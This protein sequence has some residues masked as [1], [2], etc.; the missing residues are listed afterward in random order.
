MHHIRDHSPEVLD[1]TVF[2]CR[3]LHGRKARG[4]VPHLLA[5]ITDAFQVRD[6]LD[7]RNDHAQIA[8]G[9][10]ARGENAAAL[11]VNGDLHIVD[12]VVV[13]RHCLTQGTVTLDERR[14]GF[15][16]L[17]LNEAA[18]RQN[19]AAHA[20]QVFVEAARYMVS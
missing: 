12:L 8:G 10:R 3:T 16:Q 13:H 4:D 11:L 18:H 2:V 9:G 14:H 15:L 5:L 19:L 17:L 6:R 20:L 7:N 1:L